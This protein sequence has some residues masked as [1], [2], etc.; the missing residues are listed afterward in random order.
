MR[1]YGVGVIFLLFLVSCA[2]NTSKGGEPRTPANADQAKANEC[3]IVPYT[4]GYLILQGGRDTNTGYQTL[5]MAKKDRDK[6][7]KNQIC[8]LPSSLPDCEIRAEHG[9]FQVLMAG[10]PFSVGFSGDLGNAKNFRDQH[11]LASVCKIPEQLP[12]CTIHYDATMITITQDERDVGVGFAT[13]IENAKKF[14]K[15]LQNAQ[16]C[17]PTK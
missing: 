14:L 5:E 8:N 13:S 9:D 2:T 3:Q 1:S 10:K 17:T 4:D 12:T 16:A 11:V 15:G 7:V 6:L